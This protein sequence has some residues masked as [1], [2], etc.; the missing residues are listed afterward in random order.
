MQRHYFKFDREMF[1]VVS[2]EAIS[3]TNEKSETLYP[4]AAILY[5]GVPKPFRIGL[6]KVWK[7]KTGALPLFT[8]EVERSE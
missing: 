1:V 4:S 3:S 6:K 5:T 8:N 7:P 2:G